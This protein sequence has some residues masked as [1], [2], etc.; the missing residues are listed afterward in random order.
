VDQTDSSA[1]PAPDP[2]S[3]RPNPRDLPEVL[4]NPRVD[5]D[6]IDPPLL[7]ATVDYEIGVWRAKA[8]ADHIFEWVLDY[9]LRRSER[10]YLSPGRA[11]EITK[12]AMKATF[13][14]G[15]DRGVPGEILLHAIC[16]QFYGSD[17]VINKVWFKTA[18]NDT[19]KGF[20]GVHAVHRG[21]E[22]ELWLGEAK[23]YKDVDR[24]LQS[25]LNELQE[26]LDSDYLR[27]EFALVA[28]KIGD[29]HPHA[30][31][32]R[33]LMHK[34][35]SLD[36]VFDRLVIPILVTYDSSSTLAHTKV[37]PE[38]VTD[39]KAEVRRIWLKL[40]NKLPSGLPVA[41]RLFL[42]PL[43]DKAALQNE[44]TTELRKWQ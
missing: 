3:C 27:N 5:D 33:R 12:R 39:L 37:C 44:L 42:V 16:R 19:Y 11:L 24:A 36:E 40:K 38:Y 35:T 6:A 23:F 25:V 15:G 10:E 17:T 26:H 13:G 43:G 18:Q 14:N 32:L 9:S 30:T 22:L 21:A 8:L 2:C 28:S 1:L 31:E 34:N 29:D 4:L 7:V 41:F 20:D